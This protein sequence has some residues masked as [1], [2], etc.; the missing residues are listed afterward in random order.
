VRSRVAGSLSNRG[1]SFNAGDPP[2]T[3]T[4]ATLQCEPHYMDRFHLTRAALFVRRS[5]PVGG[6]AASPGHHRFPSALNNVRDALTIATI[7]ALTAGGI[8]GQAAMTA[9]R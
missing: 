2:T 7:P 9:V 3:F 6:L 5:V 8:A 1:R 4:G